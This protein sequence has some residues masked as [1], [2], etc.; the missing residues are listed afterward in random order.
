M[1]LFKLPIESF[2]QYH[3]VT[4]F[5][6]FEYVIFCVSQKGTI[7]LG[8]F[9]TIDPKNIYF[10]GKVVF[11]FGVVLGIEKIKKNDLAEI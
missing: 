9:S 1:P 7:T 6:M 11:V 10:N 2:L 4:Y 3:A 5:R 8:M